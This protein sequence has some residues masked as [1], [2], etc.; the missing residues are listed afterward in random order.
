MSI[1]KEVVKESPVAR[2][3]YQV[4]FFIMLVN[5]LLPG[6]FPQEIR[7]AF[8]SPALNILMLGAC[9]LV[10]QRL[11]RTALY[12]LILGILG[13]VFNWY[14]GYAGLVGLVVFSVF[15][16]IV[17]FE[18]FS[19]LVAQKN[20][21][22]SEIFGAFDGYMLIGYIGA[23]LS[24]AIHIVD[25]LAYSNIDPGRGSGQDLLYFSYIT[26]LT[27]GY[28]DISPLIS[29]SKG[30]SIVLGLVGQFYL[31]VVLATF[32]GKFLRD[33]NPN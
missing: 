20:I 15:V 22:V 9:F 31:V 28:G 29:A 3:K 12:I 8:I 11:R 33:S 23:L 21:G 18:L 17:A 27:I 4:L 7:T 30:L 1:F 5:I 32:V 25:P 19:D 16:G 26:M 24:L 10:I 14:E 2:Y 6:F 13:V